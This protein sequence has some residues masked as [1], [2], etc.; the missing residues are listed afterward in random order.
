MR[1]NTNKLVIEGYVY[2]HNL[3]IKKVERADSPNLGKE[4]ISGTLDVAT[5]ENCM[6]TLSVHF[7]Y[8]T[9][10]TK[11]GSKNFTYAALKKIIDEGKTVLTDGKENAMKVKCTPAIALNDFY[12]QG[13]DELVS[14]PRNEGG[15]VTIINK[16]DLDEKDRNKFTVDML[17]NKVTHVEAD[18]EKGIEQDFTRVSGAIFNFRN[19]LL[20]FTVVAR[21]AGAMNYFEGLNVT[22]AEPVYTQLWG[23]IASTTV[24]KASVTESAFG[25][26]SVETSTRTVKEYIVTGAK[27]VPYDYG[28]DET[29]TDEDVKKAIQDRNVMLAEVKKRSEEYYNNKN[30]AITSEGNTTVPAGGFQF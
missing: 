22:G 1:T 24:K 7:T 16:F 3:N 21:D 13:Q 25:E 15:F 23:K 19:D 20:P 10:T 26:D 5:D 2:Q 11:N 9:E 28:T 30:N 29:I 18:P 12:P 14:T 8:V 27:K 17:I 4:F 6:N